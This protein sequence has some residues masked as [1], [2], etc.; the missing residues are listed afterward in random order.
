MKIL[1]DYRP[2]LRERS[3]VGETV[4]QLSKALGSLSGEKPQID[5]TLFSSS[6]R[7][8]LDPASLPTPARLIDCRIPVRLLNL[9]WHR[10]EWP[11]IETITGSDYDVVHSSNPLLIPSSKAAQVITIHD[12]YFLKHPENT[13]KEIRR[14]YTV[15]VRQHASRADC[16]LVPSEY[17][18][19]QV[20]NILEI[21]DD[22][23]VVCPLGT[24]PSLLRREQPKTGPILFIGTLEARKNINGLLDAYTLLLDRFKDAPDLI[25]VGRPTSDAS[26]WASRLLAAPLLGRVRQMGYVTTES[27]EILLKQARMLVLPSF[28]EGFGL[29]ILE[30]MSAGVPIVASNRGALPEVLGDTG[31][32]VDPTDAQSLANAIQKT[33]SDSHHVRVSVARGIQRAAHYSWQRS[34]RILRDAY[35]M[36]IENRRLNI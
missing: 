35:A 4:F 2:A 26:R 17:T 10:W 13:S 7:D 14:D 1:I 32:L 3:G 24:V 5:L 8:R 22:H 25:L 9:L 6:I 30:A 19:Q 31:L 11:R 29:P 27:R 36:A 15:L 12:L 20:Q 23:I 16:I 21:S 33:L 18:R 34:A 28:D